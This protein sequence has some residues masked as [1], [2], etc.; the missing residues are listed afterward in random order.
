MSWL[1]DNINSIVCGDSYKLIKS[2]PDKSIDMIYTDPP[3]DFHCGMG[4]GGIFKNRIAGKYDDIKGTILTKGIDDSILNEFVRIMKNIN[5]YLWCNKVQIKSY[6]NFFSDYDTLFEILTWYKAN[7]T[8]MTKNTFLPDTE[9]CL[10]FRQKGMSLNDGYELKHKYFLSK[11][12]KADKELYMH[13]TIKPLPFVKAHILHSTQPN[14][15]VLDPFA[16]S[17]TTCVAC[18]ETE[19]RYLGIEIDK[20]YHKI[21]V[22]RLNGITASGQT[23]IFTDFGGL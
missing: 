2:I 6:L 3:Y 20:Y 8:P 4:D 5:I 21:S 11:Q 10:Y 1:D 16:G 17:G 22:D 13:P 7:P 18:R 15:I 14:D 9:Y 23:S 19:R 12:N